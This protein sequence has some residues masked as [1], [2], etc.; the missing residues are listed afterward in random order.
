MSEGL[1]KINAYYDCD[2]FN[3]LFKDDPIKC[4]YNMANRKCNNKSKISLSVTTRINNHE[5]VKILHLC[6]KHYNKCVK[7][8]KID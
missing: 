5:D 6:K 8:K 2:D 1:L 3:D 4:E 7:I